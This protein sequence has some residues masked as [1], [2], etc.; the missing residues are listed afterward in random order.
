MLGSR[1]RVG[2]AGSI[3]LCLV[4][5]GLSAAPAGAVRQAQRAGQALQPAPDITCP[6]DVE[7]D[8]P[9]MTDPSVTG[10][11]TITGGVPPYDTTYSDK[12]I[13][14]ECGLTRTWSVTDAAGASDQCIQVI[15]VHDTIPPNFLFC[16]ADTTISCRN[17]FW[18][19]PHAVV[20]DNCDDDVEVLFEFTLIPGKC[21]DRLTFFREWHATDNC[22]NL[23]TCLQT[24]K[25]RDR[26]A[27]Q[28]TCA[29]DETVG[30]NDEVVFTEP[31]IVDNCDP[32]PGLS[33]ESTVTE[34]GPGACEQTHI[35]TWVGRDACGNVSEPCSQRI[36]QVFDETPPTIE[37]AASKQ[38]SCGDEVVFDP[39]QVSDECDP[40]PVVTFTD[41]VFE[42]DCAYEY[43]IERTW[44]ATDACGNAGS[45]AQLI[46]V[47][48][49]ISP[50]LTCPPSKEIACNAALV[51]DTPTASDNCDPSPVIQIVST[52]THEGDGRCV[53]V[54]TRTWQAEDACGNLSAQCS[55]TITRIVDNM[56]PMLVAQ[57]NKILACNDPVTF[58]APGISDNCD[59]D[60]VREIVSTVIE[61]GPE[62]C[63]EIHTRCWAGVDACGNDSDPVCQSVTVKVDDEPPV[64]TCAPDKTIP[65]GE[66]PIFDEPTVDDNCLVSSDIVET[67][68]TQTSDPETQQETYER[69]WI[70]ADDCGN[71]SNECCQQITVEGPPPPY[72]TFRCWDWAADCLPDPNTPPSTQPACLRDMYF[73]DL[74]PEGVMVGKEGGRTAVWTNPLAIEQFLCSYGIPKVLKRDYVNPKRYELLGVLVGETLC[75]R[76][77]RDFSCAGHMAGLGYPAPDACFGDFAVPEEVPWFAG[78]T[79]DEF[80]EVC[81]QVV[82][83]NTSVLRNYGA[84]I[85]HLYTVSVYVN[86]LFSGCSGNQTDPPILLTSTGGGIAQEETVDETLPTQVSLSVQPNPLFGSTTLRL[87]IPVDATV[88]VAVYDIQGRQVASL[89]SGHK[90]AGYHEMAWEARDADGKAV[91]PG[92]YFVRVEVGGEAAQLKK[93]IKM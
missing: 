70:I 1:Y 58:D 55:Q 75:L 31:G 7:V 77:N 13:L 57:P 83:G 9:S 63:V 54:N 11:P 81:D 62:P 72:C 44:V 33:I 2:N 65:Y 24:V 61:D 23:T 26:Q 88:A 80:L 18:D 47:V 38:I 50:T 10:L 46:E 17:H 16:P 21:R 43:S 48:D 19:L 30:C 91:V 71:I 22:G 87:A 5:L 74:Y 37:C 51:F 15:S 3:L 29:P 84:N 90:T 41:N 12:K 56:P 39:P 67:S 42:G 73:Y 64:L 60:P 68:N 40:D 79:V 92:V 85:D 36:V 93:L 14:G 89:M 59:P 78:L 49:N 20:E 76:L 4:I 45:C 34:A 28:L 6:G 66:E 86:W 52:L 53:E 27:P 69:C 35:R 32:D 8:C 82:S 25:V